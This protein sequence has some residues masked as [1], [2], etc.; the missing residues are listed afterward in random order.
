[1]P[2]EGLCFETDFRDQLPLQEPLEVLRIGGFGFGEHR[3]IDELVDG[4]SLH[5]H[6][7]V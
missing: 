4:S 6:G 3:L 1:M 5:G 2:V 7:R